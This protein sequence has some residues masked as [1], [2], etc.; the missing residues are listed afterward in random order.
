M[1]QKGRDMTTLA[2]N[3]LW[4][5][6]DGLGLTSNEANWLSEKLKSK[7]SL[8]KRE[9]QDKV[10]SS[11]EDIIREKFKDLK[12][13]PEIRKFRGSIKLSENELNDEKVQYILSK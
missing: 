10:Q 1:A 4:N 12:I 3:N 2:I 8:L 6:L 5:Y 11:K 13:S 9:S 7:A